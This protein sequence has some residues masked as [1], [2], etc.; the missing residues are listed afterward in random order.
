MSNGA[1]SPV[2]T[3]SRTSPTPSRP[4]RWLVSF[5]ARRKIGWEALETP[6]SLWQEPVENARAANL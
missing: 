2:T 3:P 6:A 1:S 5:A 4:P